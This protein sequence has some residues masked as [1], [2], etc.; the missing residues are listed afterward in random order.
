MKIFLAVITT[1]LMAIFYV[2][3]NAF[4][5]GWAIRMDWNRKYRIYLTK[6]RQVARAF[7]DPAVL[8]AGGGVALFLA[9]A[10]TEITSDYDLWWTTF[11]IVCTG[12]LPIWATCFALK[13]RIRTID[14]NRT[15]ANRI[16]LITA[17]GL[18]LWFSKATISSEINSI[19]PF[20]PAL[21]PFALTAGTFLALCGMGAIPAALFMIIMQIAFIS[22]IFDRTSRKKSKIKNHLLLLA[23]AAL[24]IGVDFS[25]SA[26]SRIGLS[27]FRTLLISRIAYE[28]D[29]NDRHL[30]YTLKERARMPLPKDEKV[31]FVGAAQDRGIAATIKAMPKKPVLQL[32]KDEVL[33]LY[34]TGFHSV[35]C[36]QP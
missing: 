24:F 25:A 26:L 1:L 27:N 14:A 12:I 11:V 2:A 30:C 21:L 20:D 32:T 28:Y 16:G 17:V 7:A 36:N 10:L 22:A 4:I 34:P 6:R 35:A 19:F 9:Y 3:L 8:V 31:L 29:F 5:I 23:P 33:A 15:N 18:L 13:A